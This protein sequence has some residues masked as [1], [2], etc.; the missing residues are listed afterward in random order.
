M[1]LLTNAGRESGSAA[2]RAARGEDGAC[3]PPTA[4]TAGTTAAAPAAGQDCPPGATRYRWAKDEALLAA[5]SAA[6]WGVRV[7]GGAVRASGENPPGE[8][9]AQ[10][11]ALVFSTKYYKIDQ[12]TKTIF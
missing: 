12:V 3:R 8:T 4:G 6:G 9:A 10:A 1:K 2:W 11:S 5:H 7:V